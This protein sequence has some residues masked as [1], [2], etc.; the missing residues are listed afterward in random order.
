MTI[1]H[2]ISFDKS[3]PYTMT[4]QYT[5]LIS[6]DSVIV[7][8]DKNCV[9]PNTVL[10]YTAETLESEL[11]VQSHDEIGRWRE[12][13]FEIEQLERGEEPY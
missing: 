2:E 10:N 13:R 9:D 5:Q 12:S 3:L 7:S 6:S 1:Y 8:V 11:F 4:T